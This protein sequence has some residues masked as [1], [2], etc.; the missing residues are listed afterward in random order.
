ML[1]WCVSLVTLRIIYNFVVKF[2]NFSLFIGFISF[3]R[4]MLITINII[5]YPF[6]TFELIDNLSIVNTMLLIYC[7]DFKYVYK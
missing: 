1:N 7:V 6:D 5:Y 2:Y 3:H 4:S